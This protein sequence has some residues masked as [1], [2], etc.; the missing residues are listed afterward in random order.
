M[1]A[2]RKNSD[3]TFTRVWGLPISPNPNKTEPA[4]LLEWENAK[5]RVEDGKV[6]RKRRGVWVEIPRE[7]VGKVTSRQTIA[8][9]QSK[10][11]EHRR[12]GPQR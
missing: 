10:K 7:W 6:Y 8:A 9:R 2:I 1:S 4:T 12:R 11:H 5:V 3:G